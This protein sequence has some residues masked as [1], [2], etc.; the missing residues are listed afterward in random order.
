MGQKVHPLGFRLGIT[1]EHKTKWYANF[2]NYANQL[3]L[4]DE[5]R[6]VWINLLKELSKKQLEEITDRTNIVITYPPTRNQIQIT[7][8]CVNPELVISDLKTIPYYIRLSKS[9]G[10]ELLQRNLVVIL[11]KVKTP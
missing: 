6:N 5:L 2:S 9:L 3:K 8:F 10:K 4:T 11:K 1:E 7:I